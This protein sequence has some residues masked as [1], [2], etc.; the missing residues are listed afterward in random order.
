MHWLSTPFSLVDAGIFV[1]AFSGKMDQPINLLP[2]ICIVSHC[3]VDL[4]SVFYLKASLWHY[5]PFRKMLGGSQVFFM[6][7]GYSLQHMS[8]FVKMISSWLRNF[9]HIAKAHLSLCTVQSDVVSAA[10]AVGVSVVSS[11]RQLTGHEFLLQLNTF[12][13]DITTTV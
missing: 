3:S 13:V 7:L 12:S 10:V 5:E 11:C 6:V 1:V 4:C 8:L 2:Q 9:L